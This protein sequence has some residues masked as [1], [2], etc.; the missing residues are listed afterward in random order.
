MKNIKIKY[1][2]LTVLL[3]AISFSGWKAAALIRDYGIYTE[4]KEDRAEINKVNYG[5]FNLQLWKKEAMSVFQNRIQDFDIAP[6]AYKEVEAEL[7]KYLRSIYRDYIESG[8]IFE[9]VFES[10]EK[11]EKV[12]KFFLKLIKENVGEQIQNLHIQKFIPGMAKE[13]ASELKKQEPRIKEV[14]QNELKKMLKDEDSES[15]TDPRQNIY[16]KYSTNDLEDTNLILDEKIL[17][18]E[19][20]ISYDIRYLYVLLIFIIVIAT[21]GY[22]ILGANLYISVL[23]LS[24][25]VFLMAGVSLPMIDIE[26]ILNAFQLNV[27]GTSIGFNHQVIYFQSKSILDVTRTLIEGRG[28]DLKIVG[29]MILAFSIVFPFFKL[30]FSAFFLY[31]N[32][33]QNSRVVKNLIFYLGKWSM[34]DVFVVAMFMAYIGFQGLVTAQ[35]GDIARNESGFAVETLNK[36]KLSPGALFFTTYCILSIITGILIHKTAV[37]KDEASV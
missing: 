11:S 31:S 29:L 16:S 21:T 20:N 22:K 19:S 3:I 30:L 6:S 1:A 25:I 9:G 32:R 14:M 2:F 12:N 35:L 36:S 17:Q 4:L 7:E 15:F 27:L 23:T 5:L 13:L 33:L 26:A 8:K 28:I 34:A 18:S 10:A 37:R 24:S